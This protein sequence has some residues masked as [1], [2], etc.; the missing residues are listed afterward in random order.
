MDDRFD[1]L[2]KKLA[3]EGMS[4]RRMVG[5]VF[6]A[7]G[8]GALATVAGERSALAATP[9]KCPPGLANCNGACRDTSIN[10]DHCGGC[11]VTCAPGQMCRNGMCV[12]CTCSPPAPAPCP[13][14]QIVCNGTCVDPRT[15]SRNCGSCGTICPSGQTCRSG[16]CSTPTFCTPGAGQAC[17]T[18]P[19]GTQGVG[20]CQAGTQTC[21]ADGSAW[22]ACTGQQTPR[23]EI[24]GNGLD[25]DCD[26]VVDNGCCPSGTTNC[27]GTC[28][29]T[30]SDPA[31]CGACGQ[32]CAA[33]NAT[34]TCVQ[35]TCNIGGCSP[36]FVDCNGVVAD[37][38]ECEGT[39]C[40][41]SG[42]QTKHSN[43]LGQ[44]FFDCTALGTYNQM[45]ANEAAQAWPQVGTVTTV[46]CDSG[47]ALTKQTATQCATWAY[48]GTASGHVV[49]GSTCVCPSITDASWS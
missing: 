38:C 41:G 2:T 16:A 34:A 19:A 45:Q 18:G 42:C 9:L 8:G 26:G 33:P 7:L 43:G 10:P 23:A 35:G 12:A 32:V 27:G 39:A 22:G 3:D 49:V 36:G 25:D 20:I 13:T 14:G 15:D 17:Y 21:L 37:G 11:G 46:L 29:N 40:C 48:S 24:C 6:A 4:R 30:S 47:S 28:V 5:R 31:N 1:D 44:S